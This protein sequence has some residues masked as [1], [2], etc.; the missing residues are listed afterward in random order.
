V[1]RAL[2]GDRAARGAGLHPVPGYGVPAPDGDALRV[3]VEVPVVQAAVLD[4]LAARA[5]LSV[6]IAGPRS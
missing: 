1:I 4:A 3:D 2:R 6:R 5:A